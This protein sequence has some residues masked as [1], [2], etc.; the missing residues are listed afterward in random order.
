MLPLKRV[1]LVLQR[2]RKNPLGLFN[3]QVG[4]HPIAAGGRY[5][6]SQELSRLGNIWR[7]SAF[8]SRTRTRSFAAR[9]E[10]V[11]ATDC[12]YNSNFL[13]TSVYISKIYI[14]FLSRCFCSITWMRPGIESTRWRYLVYILLAHVAWMDLPLSAFKWKQIH[15]H[16][17]KHVYQITKRKRGGCCL[18]TWG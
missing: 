16:L 5:Y 3:H 15:T 14:K 10:F 4:F 7:I 11:L 18:M 1:A 6:N 8:S 12:Q 17:V 9:V 2:S 13:D